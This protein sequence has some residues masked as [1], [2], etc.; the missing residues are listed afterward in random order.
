[1]D[2]YS[3]LDDS[4]TRELFRVL[5][6]VHYDRSPYPVPRTYFTSELVISSYRRY[7]TRCQYHLIAKS[8][9]GKHNPS[10]KSGGTIDE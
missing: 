4:S 6:G 8:S 7:C 10:R 2:N 9:A 3:S 1:M 5:R